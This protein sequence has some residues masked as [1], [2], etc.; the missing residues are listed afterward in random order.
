MDVVWSMN[1]IEELAKL[2][3]ADNSQA[4]SMW[5]AKNNAPV[6]VKRDFPE[7]EV[8]E[9]PKLPQ[10]SMFFSQLGF[11]DK[12]DF[13]EEGS[14]EIVCVSGGKKSTSIYSLKD[15]KVY[16]DWDYAKELMITK[17]E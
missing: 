15:F 4:R 10:V 8:E 13:T 6:Y 12:S 7:H 17:V 2:V 5:Q 3:E 14:I 11:S 9:N 16:G 1:T